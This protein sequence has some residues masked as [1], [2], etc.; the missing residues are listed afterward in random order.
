[1]NPTLPW[2]L[3]GVIVAVPVLG[4]GVLQVTGLVAHQ[5]TTTVAHIPAAGIDTL[6]VHNSAGGVRVIGTDSTDT[7]TVTTHVSEGL[8]PTGHRMTT[9]GH[10]LVL[11]GTCPLITNTWCSVGYTVEVPRAVALDLRVDGGIRAADIDGPI[12][13]STDQG[14][15]TLERVHGPVDLS[16]DQGSITV[17]G[18]AGGRARAHSD[19]G[20]VHLSFRDS[21]RTVDAQT[22]QG[23]IEIV[24]PKETGVEFATDTHT[25]Q[26]SVSDQINQNPDSERTI[27]AHSDQG[28]V[29][30]RYRRS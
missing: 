24:L 7:I 19:Q 30:L 8:R 11:T 3:A 13:V 14:R 16:T 20:S 22:D 26:G 23:S 10:R 17:T 28:D 21:P 25:D 6:E 15:I 5:E 27:R 29:T 4:F 12:H 1:M 18:L 9:E 2:R